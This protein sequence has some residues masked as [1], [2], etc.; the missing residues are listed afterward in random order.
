VPLREPSVCISLY[1]SPNRSPLSSGPFLVPS[2][3]ANHGAPYSFSDVDLGLG[4]VRLP[5]VTDDFTPC[6]LVYFSLR[7]RVYVHPAR[8]S[9]IACA[10]END[11]TPHFSL[12]R[13]IR[14]P[15]GPCL[16]SCDLFS[17]PFTVRNSWTPHSF[18][19]IRSGGRLTP[20]TK[21]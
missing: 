21:H 4:L 15:T 12:T 17:L 18:L 5:P 20:C 14:R 9:F 6:Y 19:L 16:S 1:I 10:N 8:R 3:M 7:P 13:L 11:R 2:T